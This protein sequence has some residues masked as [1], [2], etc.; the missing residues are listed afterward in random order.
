MFYRG[1]I[2]KCNILSIDFVLAIYLFLFDLGIKRCISW[3]LRTSQKYF[4]DIKTICYE[5]SLMQQLFLELCFFIFAS[6]LLSSYVNVIK[7]FLSI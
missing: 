4:Y 3:Y 7:V 6:S 1:T 5:I 2:L